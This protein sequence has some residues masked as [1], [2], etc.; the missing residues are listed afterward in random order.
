MSNEEKEYRCAYKE[1]V[2]ILDVFSEEI[3]DLI[4]NEKYIAK[5]ITPEDLEAKI[6]IF[7]D[8]EQGASLR[9]KLEGKIKADY[10]EV[11][12]EVS[13]EKLAKLVN[14]EKKNFLLKEMAKEEF[15]RLKGLKLEEMLDNPNFAQS[16]EDIKLVTED[17]QNLA[18]QRFSAEYKKLEAD[19]NLSF[20]DR[21]MRTMGFETKKTKLL[22]KA[23]KAFKKEK[24]LEILKEEKPEIFKDARLKVKNFIDAHQSEAEKY[25]N[26]KKFWISLLVN[27]FMVTASC[28]ALNWIHPRVNN[29]I[30]NKKAEKNAVNVQKVEVK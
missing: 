9:K 11:G 18:R 27:L 20:F 7:D 10:S 3:S 5:G 16:I 15:E 19:A 24:G 29:Y 1:I 2:T 26:N 17:Y 4:P 30:E 22:D 13:D 21:L 6:A 14:K 12:L 28:F 23:Q 25:F 8:P